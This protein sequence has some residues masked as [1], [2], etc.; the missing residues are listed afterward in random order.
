MPWLGL[1]ALLAACGSPSEVTWTQPDT[2]GVDILWVIDS[3]SSMGEEQETLATG[4]ISF[5]NEL[6]EDDF[7]IAVTTMDTL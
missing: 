6:D 3:S 5:I 2:V 7:R 4:F 1:T